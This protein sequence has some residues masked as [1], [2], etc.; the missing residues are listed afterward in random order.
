MIKHTLSE[1]AFRTRYVAPPPRT[2]IAATASYALAVQPCNPTM[3]FALSTVSYAVSS[4]VEH[5]PLAYS[6]DSRTL[7]N[8]Q[9]TK[10]PIMGRALWAIACLNSTD[11]DTLLSDTINKGFNTFECFIPAHHPSAHNAPFD[12]AGNA[13]FLKRLDGG[14]WTG[15]LSYSNINNEAPDFTTPNPS[16]WTNIDKI[17]SYAHWKGLSI[18]M[19]PAYFGFAGGDE[20]WMAEM[21]ANGQTKMQTYGA[22]VAT[23]YAGCPNIVWMV[24][25]DYEASTTAEKNAETGLITGLSS[26]P[27]RFYSAEWNSNRIG[28]DNTDFASTITL[29]SVY[30]FEGNV[31]NNGRRAYAISPT[32]PAFLLEEPYDQE[33]P[34]GENFNANATQPIRRFLWWGWLSTIG[35]YIAGNG[36]VWKM[37]PGV[38]NLSSHLNSQTAQDSARLNTFMQS[39]DWT[40]LIPSGLGSMHTIV[41]AGG[42]TSTS[43]DY[44][45]AAATADGKL[46]L[47]YVPPDH[48]GTITIDMTT[49]SASSRGRWFNPTTAT[50]TDITGGSFNLAN[51]GTHVFTPPGDNGTGFTDWLLVLDTQ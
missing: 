36:Y 24:G 50:Y 21:V 16:Y 6:S 42:S 1:I 2:L 49:M 12:S 23:R 15:S 5:F 25:G 39:I 10:T 47:A 11:L 7:V 20:G 26:G 41:T 3:V 38:W 33:G 18:F 31:N 8:A 51:T 37:N 9:G 43:T 13:P 4:P 17:V 29:D 32:L 34:D 48:A 14:T 46:C 19:F 35:G 45:T 22:W 44:V 30:S 28:K 27:N 40:H